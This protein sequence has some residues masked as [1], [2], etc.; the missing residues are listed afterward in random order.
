M[1]GTSTSNAAGMATR[2]SFPVATVGAALVALLF[3]ALVAA[4]WV[5]FIESDDL[6]Y[7]L[8]AG[9]WID[10]FPHLGQ[11][12]WGLRHLIVLPIAASFAL[13]GRSEVTLLVPTMLY[14]AAIVA[15]TG[16]CVRRVAGPIAGVLAALLVVS[17]P[18]VITG[19]SMVYSDTIETFF[20][21]ASLWAYWF[22]T[23]S[24]RAGLFLASGILAGCAFITRETT[25]ALLA[26][27]L[28]LFL[29]APRRIM[30]F[31]RMG[32]GFL[33]VVGIDTAWLWAASGD[34]FWRF[35]VSGRGVAGDNPSLAHFQVNAGGL[36]R[37]SVIIA[38][39]PLQALLAVFANH[40]MGLLPWAAVPAAIALARRRTAGRRRS[41]AIH[42]SGLALVWFLLLSYAFTFM[43]IVP[44]YQTVTMVAL[45][46]P[47][48]IWLAER[49]E[50]GAWRL[51]ALLVA[52]I[53][54][55]GAA[56]A[57][58][59]DRELLF[60]ERGLVAFA[61]T[62]EGPIRTDP[63]TL[64]GADWLL[65]IEGLRDRVSAGPCEPGGL[66]YAN[67]R[68]RRTLPADWTRQAVPEGATILLEVP[69][70]TTMMARIL[71][72]VGL[73]A[74]MPGVVRNKLSP[75]PIV[76]RGF[77]MPG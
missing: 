25:V 67:P 23:R 4:T 64:R 61:R 7:A 37:H 30:D 45:C 49:I 42:F 34:P 70:R 33:I 8:S 38:P 59:A 2:G 20:V 13:F 43:W 47:L 68:P 63:A 21:L 11:S 58:V 62:T 35:T 40:L 16:L 6:A 14:A 41:A 29:L 50:A 75:T 74:I 18:V 46:V 44:R 52:A 17:L 65:Q 26:F 10:E 15:M 71:D 1:A 24:G 32:A 53:L 27:Y 76:A 56:L 12:H 57:L 72:Q 48:A 28:V 77:R 60:G 51:P 31:V 69:R 54:G 66:C 3:A 73:L 55:I 39:R 5:G 36:D 22:A 9:L 19:A